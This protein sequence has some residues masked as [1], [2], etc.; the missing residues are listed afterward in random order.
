MKQLYAFQ[1][2]AVFSMIMLALSGCNGNSGADLSN[3]SGVV[4]TP[5]EPDS[6][7]SIPSVPEELRS[8]TIMW[9][10]PIEKE[11]GEPLTPDELS[12]FQI[13]YGSLHNPYENVISIDSPYITSFTINEL[14]VGEY[15]FSI[16]AVDATGRTSSFS[17]SIVKSIS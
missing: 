6:T 15:S 17:N 5:T 9:S 14:P 13:Y 3:T 16:V 4:L 7:P 11:N 10:A 12:G 2:F 8:A 1:K